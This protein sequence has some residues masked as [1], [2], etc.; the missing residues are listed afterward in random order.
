[1]HAHTIAGGIVYLSQRDER[2]ELG[3]ELEELHSFL[4]SLGLALGR[5]NAQAAARRLSEDLAE[6]NRR[7]QQMQAEVLRTRTLSIIA[8]M[9]TGAGHELNG[10]LTG[11]IRTG[12]VADGEHG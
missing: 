2:V 8:E 10:P 3:P 1:M 9:A 7:L 11:D 4:T 12:A 5:V 6:S